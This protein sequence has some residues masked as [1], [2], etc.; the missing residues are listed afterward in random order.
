MI[1]QNT[2]G[3]ATLTRSY[4]APLLCCRTA[5]SHANSTHMMLSLG[6]GDNGIDARRK[7]SINLDTVFAELVLRQHKVAH[8]SDRRLQCCQQLV[9]TKGERDSSFLSALRLTRRQ[10][11]KCFRA[12]SCNMPANVQ[13]QPKQESKVGKIYTLPAPLR[14]QHPPLHETRARGHLKRS[15]FLHTGGSY[16]ISIAFRAEPNTQHLS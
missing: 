12:P 14:S 10:V 15:T 2:H 5:V 3:L 13:T 11:G 16:F 7:V 9:D 4:F 6:S 1:A 8:I